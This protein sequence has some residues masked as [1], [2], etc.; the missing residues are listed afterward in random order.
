MYFKM[1]Y[2]AVMINEALYCNSIKSPK[3]S[4]ITPNSLQLRNNEKLISVKSY[5]KNNALSPFILF[6][7]MNECC[8]AISL[9]HNLYDSY[10]G[11]TTLSNF[12]MDKNMHCSLEL[13]FGKDLPLTKET[14]YK[15]Y[16]MFFEEYYENIGHKNNYFLKICNMFK[17]S[18]MD[19]LFIRRS[20]TTI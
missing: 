9:Y 19:S 12:Y 4:S 14:N 11:N 15:D 18:Y 20:E 7:I 17:K 10:H 3:F 2:M 5:T 6:T 13:S 16:D 1:A 8:R